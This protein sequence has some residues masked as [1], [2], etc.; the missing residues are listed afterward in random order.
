MGI[1]VCGGR[2]WSD[3][4]GEDE[5]WKGWVKLGEGGF[6]G[7]G[8]ILMWFGTISM[9]TMTLIQ[10]H[11]G[12]NTRVQTKGECFLLCL[13]KKEFPSELATV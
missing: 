1:R 11:K 10:M 2:G 9:K 8:L 5:G 13:K 4:L 7:G 3:A 6:G 12:S